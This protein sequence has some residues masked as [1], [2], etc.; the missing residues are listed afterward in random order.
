[1]AQTVIQHTY[2]LKGGNEDAVNRN[3]PLLDR[4]EPIVVYC[5]DGKTRM[6]IGDGEHYY[7]DLPFIGE[8]EG[9][10]DQIV[11][12]PSRLNF[13]AI[14]DEDLLYRATK[15]SQLYQWNPTKLCY[16]LLNESNVEITIED[17]EYISGGTAADLIEELV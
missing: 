11:D 12:Y 8:G 5:K 13:P 3:N 4:R 10:K 15:D 1:M 6:K 17:I 16:E 2:H 14:G 7:K 9:G